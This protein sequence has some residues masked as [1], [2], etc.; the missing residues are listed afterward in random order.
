MA[1]Q[2]HGFKHDLIQELRKLLPST[3][4]K[5]V[6]LRARRTELDF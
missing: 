1:S 5:T 6:K 2:F 4:S 3:F